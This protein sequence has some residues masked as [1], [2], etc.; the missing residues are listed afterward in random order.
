MSIDLSLFNLPDNDDYLRH[1]KESELNS[2]E[3]LKLVNRYRQC[4]KHLFV[5]VKKH[6]Q[7]LGGLHF[8]DHEIIPERVECVYCGL[9]N[10]LI[11]TE[12]AV[13][14]GSYLRGDAYL[15]L[16]HRLET[17]G[18]TTLEFIRQFGW[19]NE[20]LDKQCFLSLEEISSYH[21]GILF[22]IARDLYFL[23][24]NSIDTG[25]SECIEDSIFAIMKEL[26]N[27]ETSYEK[28]KISDIKHT[29]ALIERYKEKHNLINSTL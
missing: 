20:K 8:S 25:E 3:Q 26:Y 17:Y 29:K 16:P 18:C 10:R 4:K 9:T 15:F 5:V 13:H 11:E 19:D 28:L 6:P 27:E 7:Y 2:S 14:E 24:G 22:R 23:H 12:E 21:P 1:C